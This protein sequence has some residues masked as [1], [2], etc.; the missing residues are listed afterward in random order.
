MT[1]LM[2]GSRGPA[3]RQL[4]SDLGFS[5]DDVDGI[6]GPATARA[7]KR[8]QSSEGLAV[9]GKAGQDTLRALAG[10]TS[11]PTLSQGDIERV[12]K[13]LGVEVAAVMAVNDV[14]SRGNGFL[15]SGNPVILFERHVMRR[16]L[17]DAG[18]D[19]D[20][21]AE[22]LPGVINRQSGGYEGGEAEHDRLHLARQVDDSCAICAAS[23]GLFQIMGHHYARLGF[24]TPQAMEAAAAE[25]EGRQLEMFAAFIES[26]ASLHSALKAR[27]WSRFAYGYNGPGY[28]DHDYDGR[29]AAAYQ[30]HSEALR[31]GV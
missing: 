30:D 10:T 28:A 5:G 17:R 14:E 11:K 24:E 22:H 21:L 15:G 31:E 26:D 7:V 25:S 6:Y 2:R 19:A 23:W 16:N 13:R 4:Q 3:V 20:L 12:A 9:D 8:F 18:R 1:L 27:D 29:M